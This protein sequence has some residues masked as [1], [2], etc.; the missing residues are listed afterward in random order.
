[1]T[2]NWEYRRRRLA[3]YHARQAAI[4]AFYRDLDNP[5]ADPFETQKRQ[6]ELGITNEQIDAHRA[7][8]QE[9][10]NF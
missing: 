5:D 2:I 7:K 4:R 9:A 8:K 10:V 3:E 1:M 6:H